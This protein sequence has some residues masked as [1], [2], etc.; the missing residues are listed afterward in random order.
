MRN[1]GVHVPESIFGYDLG[2]AEVLKFR[3]VGTGLLRQFDKLLST[4]QIAVVIGRDIR[5]EVRGMLKANGAFP[6]S[7]FHL[8]SARI[9]A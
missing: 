3:R 6:N 5:N 1:L 9:Q 7:K 2:S 8:T 4:L